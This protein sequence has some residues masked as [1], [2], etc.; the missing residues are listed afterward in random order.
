MI[1]KFIIPI[2]LLVLNLGVG[3]HI[4]CQELVEY[5]KL[6]SYERAADE[7]FASSI[8]IFGN[9][10][11]VGVQE[12]D[13]LEQG[14]VFVYK[15]DSFGI[16]SFHQKLTASNPTLGARFG[17]SVD[18]YGDY[19]AIGAYEYF[20]STTYNA[21]G[22]YIFK[23]NSVG[24]WQEQQFIPG[25]DSVLNTDH[26]GSSVSL[27]ENSLLVGCYGCE[28]LDTNGSK[29]FYSGAAYYYELDTSSGQW[30][31][32]SRFNAT[33]PRGSNIF[34]YNVILK[35]TMALLSSPNDQ[36]DQNEQNKVIQAGSVFCFTKDSLGNWTQKQKVVANN[37]ST[38]FTPRFGV[39]IDWDDDMAVIGSSGVGKVHLFKLGS[40]GYWTQTAT[41]AEPSPADTYARFGSQVSIF[42]KRILIGAPFGLNKQQER[43]GTV[44]FYEQR[45]PAYALL[46]IVGPSDGMSADEFGSCLILHDSVAMVSA[47]EHDYDT[48][49][50]S[51]AD[52]AGAVYVLQI[53]C[54]SDSLQL[55]R[56]GNTLKAPS[57]GY[58]H[59][60]WF[61]CDSLTPFT[62]ITSNAIQ[63]TSN[64]S[65]IAVFISASGCTDT[66]NCLTIA[67]LSTNPAT[68]L[69]EKNISVYPNPFSNTLNISGDFSECGVLQLRDG[70]GKLIYIKE[71]CCETEN[72]INLSDLSKGLYHLTYKSNT[73][74]QSV[75]VTKD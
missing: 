5:Q 50:T 15:K 47:P 32:V 71:R 67:D 17:N 37:R 60:E 75:R 8:D 70:T 61:M 16:W 64:G 3:F 26:F 48:S 44:Y 68:Y 65:Y 33:V 40:N 19:A 20:S 49:A 22:V 28:A 23:L 36:Y 6:I 13:S 7:G 34:G 24:L 54:V 41:I 11:F 53:A 45:G 59:Y 51:Y 38:A 52:G 42:D 35:D 1:N 4:Y 73:S 58:G 62:N 9:T 30:E 2:A 39:D 31:F 57:K 25:A 66:T 18:I 74:F 12:Q 63:I 56:Q 14:A 69:Y 72:I 29:V 46:N 43:T 21:G 27:Y 55:T 10:A